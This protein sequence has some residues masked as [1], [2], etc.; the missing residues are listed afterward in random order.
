MGVNRTV[1][2]GNPSNP[3]NQ[4]ISIS[5]STNCTSRIKILEIWT[6]K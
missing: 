1:V 3:S 6:E 2:I 4:S 5:G